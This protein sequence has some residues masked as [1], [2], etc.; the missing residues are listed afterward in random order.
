MRGEDRNGAI[1]YITDADVVLG[2]F[3]IDRY[4][5]NGEKLEV[6]TA[7]AAE[8]TVTLDNHSGSFSRV[9]LE[10]TELFVEVG[11]ADW[12]QNNPLIHWIPCG[13]FT[14]DEQPRRSSST[15]MNIRLTCLDRMTKFDVAVDASAL[16]FP[17]TVAGLV[18]QI[19]TLF[20]ITVVEDITTLPNGNVSIASLPDT[21][22][23]ITY[24][25]LIRWC[26][27]IMG[28]NAW[29]DWNGWLRFTWYNG[30][31]TGYATTVANRFDSDYYED[32]LTVTGVVYTN[33]SGVEI[34]QGTDEYA[35]DLTGNALVE[36]LVSTVLPTLNTALNGFTYRPFTA[37][38]INAPYLWPMDA[39]TF[40]S[41]D[42]S[43][44]ASALTNVNFGVNG[45]TGLESKGLTAALNAR[46]Q[47]SGVTKDQAQLIT[48]AMGRVETD[49]DNTITMIGNGA[50]K[51]GSIA[52][53]TT[54]EFK[55]TQSAHAMLILSG[56]NINLFG[57]YLIRDSSQ[58]SL[59]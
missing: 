40:T 59:T 32:G 52:S 48:E 54:K 46:R 7:I 4:S 34:V 31:S 11:I 22:G 37:S 49:I 55:S 29:F 21:V 26:A 41:K 20:G 9:V 35:I 23:E 53:G 2:S 58:F 42:G 47:P 36:P 18:G 27:G 33:S 50:F 15:Q 16:T 28:T 13:Y 8:M 30:I 6:G 25:D 14:S 44:Y 10:G 3:N 51:L 43:D 39:V 5:C 12:S 17:A 1:I 45:T 57:L 19:C 38:V 56:P 24:R